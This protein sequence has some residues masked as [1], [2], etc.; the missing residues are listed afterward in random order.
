MRKQ[1][2]NK[3]SYTLLLLFLI[4]IVLLSWI[5]FTLLGTFAGSFIFHYN[6]QTVAQD[7]YR[8]PA[9]M[10]YFQTIQ[11]ISLFILP[12]IL[13]AIIF[14]YK[15]FEWLTLTNKPKLIILFAS[16]ILTIIAQPFISFTGELNSNLTLPSFMKPIEEWMR[17]KETQAELATN[18]FLS[19]NS[20]IESIFNIFLI[21]VIPAFGEELLFRGAIQKLIY[22]SSK[23]THLAVWITAI[24]FSALH[25]QFFGFI[26]RLILGLI[27]GYLVVYFNCIWLSIT[28]H[29]TNNFLAYLIYQNSD[30]QNSNNS[31]L[32]N[33]IDSHSSIFILLSILGIFIISYLLYRYKKNTSTRA[34]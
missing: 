8:E 3:Y 22:K 15:P 10:K 29:F 30:I 31:N 26:P 1:I 32:N 25:M 6:V 4:L 14:Y 33:S 24:L 11:S 9:T 21:A 16:L 27:F 7:I 17:L 18:I 34:I 12:T 2:F 13:F 19:S 23:N 5:L 28:A 20:W